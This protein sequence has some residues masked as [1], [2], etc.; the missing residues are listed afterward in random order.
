[1]ILVHHHGDVGE[2]L[3]RRLYHVAQ[4]RG[5]CIFP[6]PGTGLHDDR[7]AGGVRRLHD[8]PGLLQVVDVESRHPVA[9]LGG[10][11][12]QLSHTDQCHGV[13]SGLFSM[14]VRCVL[15]G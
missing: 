12:Q 10:V 7:A 2:F 4:K 13:F 3:H 6:R 1:M 14:N 9:V 11:V 5:A 8:R 15:P